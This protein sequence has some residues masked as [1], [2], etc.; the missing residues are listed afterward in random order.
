VFTVIDILAVV[1]PKVLVA[2]IVYSTVPCD[3][4]GVP[5][6]IP[7]TASIINPAGNEG[8]TAHNDTEP[9]TIGILFEIGKP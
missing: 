8:D 3:A 9:V 7:V 2:V 6:M 5:D 1:N 4:V